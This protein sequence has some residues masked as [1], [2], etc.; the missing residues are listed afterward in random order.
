[1]HRIAA[2]KSFNGI[3]WDI[4]FE[5]ND[6]KYSWEGE[7]ESKANDD[8]LLIV[9]KEEYN[10]LYE[11][12]VCEKDIIVNRDAESI[13]FNGKKTVKLSPQQSVINLLRAEEQIF[14]IYYN[15]FEYIQELDTAQVTKEKIY[16]PK[17][18]V[19]NMLA[20]YK[21]IASIRTIQYYQRKI[22]QYISANKG[23]T[24]RIF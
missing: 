2:G 16:L 7:F 13:I 6:I 21:D 1:M 11:K 24:N 3:K 5:I 8:S 9:N 17:K 20:N 4:T 18:L 14:S 19:K 10:I 15:G 22:Y 12:V 23:Y